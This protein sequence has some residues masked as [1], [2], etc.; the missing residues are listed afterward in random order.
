MKLVF[1][2]APGAFQTA[3][4]TVGEL[5]PKAG[6]DSFESTATNGDICYNQTGAPT[7][8]P[9][10]PSAEPVP[11]ANRPDR[12]KQTPRLG[13]GDDDEPLHLAHVPPIATQQLNHFAQSNPTARCMS[14]TTDST[15]KCTPQASIYTSCR[16]K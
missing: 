13:S 16:Y 1:H 10:S 15:V 12:A 3:L 5:D 2:F 9:S 14:T 8:Y 11:T 4:R 7:S 6:V